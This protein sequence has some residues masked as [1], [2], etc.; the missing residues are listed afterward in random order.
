MESE[1]LGERFAIL[2]PFLQGGSADSYAETAV[3]AGLSEAALKSA[4][5]RLRRRYAEIIR[6]EIGQTVASPAEI[7]EEIRHLIKALS[8]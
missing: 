1:Q 6:E 4:I 5:H 8:G 7:E 2:K 3:R